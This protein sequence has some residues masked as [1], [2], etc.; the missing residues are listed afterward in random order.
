MSG[1]PSSATTVIDAASPDFSI[2]HR[3]ASTL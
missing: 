3:D 1:V 2:G